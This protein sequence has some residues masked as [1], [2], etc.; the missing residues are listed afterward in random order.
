MVGVRFIWLRHSLEAFGKRLKSLEIQSAYEGI[1][2]T[3]DPLA[4]RYKAK[5]QREAQGELETEHPAYLG[6]Q[7]TH[8][9]GALK[10]VGRIYQQTFVDT[11]SRFAVC[12][13]STENTAAE[14]KATHISSIWPSR[15][16]TILRR[17]LVIPRPMVFVS[18]LPFSKSFTAQWNTYKL[19]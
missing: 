14:S 3:E 2:L 7:D 6:S 5:Q 16:L 19:S 11:Y 15:T 12:K 1:G 17:R 4:A 13:L 10:G 18:T 9:V 8:Y